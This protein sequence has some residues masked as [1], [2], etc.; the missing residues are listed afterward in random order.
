VRQPR[1]SLPVCPASSAGSARRAQERPSR[2]AVCR[3]DRSASTSTTGTRCTPAWTRRLTPRAPLT[4]PGGTSSIPTILWR[5]P[6]L[7]MPSFVLVGH[8]TN[9]AARCRVQRGGMRCLPPPLA[10][11]SCR[12]SRSGKQVRQQSES[13]APVCARPAHPTGAWPY[14]PRGAGDRHHQCVA[15]SPGDGSISHA[16]SKLCESC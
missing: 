2:Q 15:P 14:T 3:A 1:P 6:P 4:S 16:M 9:N 7:T 8:A 5:T 13:H 11:P 12:C 10:H